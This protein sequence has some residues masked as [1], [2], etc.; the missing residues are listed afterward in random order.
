M[1]VLNPG[2]FPQRWFRRFMAKAMPFWVNVLNCTFLGKNC[3]M[4]VKATLTL[5]VGRLGY[6]R[7]SPAQPLIQ[8]CTSNLNSRIEELRHIRQE[9]MVRVAPL[10]PAFAVLDQLNISAD[11]VLWFRRADLFLLPP[12]L[13][14][15]LHRAVDHHAAARPPARQAGRRGLCQSHSRTALRLVAAAR[16]TGLLWRA[17]AFRRDVRRASR[18]R[19]GLAGRAGAGDPAVN[20]RMP[21]FADQRLCP[22]ISFSCSKR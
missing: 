16:A 18:I 11:R 5:A 21:A 7:I 19:H 1:S 12:R 14:R 9:A 6:S 2:H 4:S 22:W 20:A 3:R 8:S 13:R 10:L 17:A 15:L